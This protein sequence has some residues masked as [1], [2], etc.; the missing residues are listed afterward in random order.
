[1]SSETPFPTAEHPGHPRSASLAGRV[2]AIVEVVLAFSLVHLAYRSIKHFT[3]LG[4]LE[5]EAGLNFSPGT[6]MVLF[7]VAMLLLC[8]RDFTEYRLTL[9]RWGYDLN[10]GL[11]WA[12]VVLATAGFV[13][14]VSPVRVDPLHPP[15]LPKALIYSCGAVVLTLLLARFL[16]RERQL[17]RAVP[18]AADVAALLGLLSLPLVVAWHFDRP[19]P[20]VLFSVLWLFLGTGFGE[21]VFFR[22]YVQSRVNEAFGRPYRRWGVRVGPGVVISS[23]LFGFI[24]ALNTVDYFGGRYDFAWL[25]LLSNSFVGLFF[26]VLREGTGSVLPGAILHGLEDVLGHIP[27]LLP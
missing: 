15:D 14:V 1:M 26:G 18:P 24:H 2:A 12:G 19:L 3:E 25:W 22:G 20:N 27:S 21:E 16:S 8:R 6:A 7:T 10:V 4:R 23:L 9:K 5:G 17:P 13:L 11:V